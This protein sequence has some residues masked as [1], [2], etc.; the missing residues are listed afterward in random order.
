VVV[1]YCK[2]LRASELIPEIAR[3]YAQGHID[4]EACGPLKKLKIEIHSPAGRTPEADLIWTLKGDYTARIMR[5]E[6]VLM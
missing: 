3:L 4:E 2:R 5:L 6:E 1:N